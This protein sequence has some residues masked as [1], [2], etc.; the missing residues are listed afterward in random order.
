MDRAELC[1][2]NVAWGH[3]ASRSCWRCDRC[4]QRQVTGQNLLIRVPAIWD[5]WECLRAFSLLKVYAKSEERIADVMGCVA[6]LSWT[7]LLLRNAVF[8]STRASVDSAGVMWSKGTVHPAG[9]SSTFQCLANGN[10]GP[11]VR[12]VSLGFWYWVAGNGCWQQW[13]LLTE[14]SY[15]RVAGGTRQPRRCSSSQDVTWLFKLCLGLHFPIKACAMPW[16]LRAIT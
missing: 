8:G 2:E 7:L 4:H 12:N 16:L 11:R 6:S 3:M 14:H 9:F 10:L 5:L 13:L 1:G 15:R